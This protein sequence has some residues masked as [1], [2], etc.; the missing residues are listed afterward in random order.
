MTARHGHV[1]RPS[2]V[3][4]PAAPSRQSVPRWAVICAALSPVLLTAAYLLA[5]ML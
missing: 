5:G 1:F 3:T 4:D 2:T